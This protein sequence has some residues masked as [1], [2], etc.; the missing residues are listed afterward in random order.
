MAQYQ[1]ALDSITYSFTAN[2]DPTVGTDTAR[3][4]NWVV[5]DGSRAH[6]SNTPATSTLDDVHVAPTVTA[7]AHRDLHRRRHARWRSMRP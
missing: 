4:I 5:N 7:G 6:G 1:A 3:T 2:G